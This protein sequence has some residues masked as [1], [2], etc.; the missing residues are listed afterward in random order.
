MMVWQGLLLGPTMENVFLSFYEV[1]WLKQCPKEFEPVF[2]RR[3]VDDIFVLFGSAEHLSKFRNYFD[4][5]HRNMSF[6][7]E[8]EKMERCHFLI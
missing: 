2:Y 4:T 1:K 6:Y 3:Y 8:Q 7:V 5:C